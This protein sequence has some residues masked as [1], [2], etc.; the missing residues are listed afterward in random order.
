M[1]GPVFGSCL[2]RA[3][4]DGS[5]LAVSPRGKRDYGRWSVRAGELCIKF[6]KGLGGRT[7]CNAIVQEAGWYVG[8][9]GEVQT[10][11]IGTVAA[12]AHRTAQ[13]TKAV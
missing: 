5:F 7:R 8:S 13:E 4:G 1:C 10:R 2:L 6:D 3:R 12:S 9:Q 11:L